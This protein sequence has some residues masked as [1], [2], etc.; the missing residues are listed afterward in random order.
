MLSETEFWYVPV[1]SNGSVTSML[2]IQASNSG[3]K[4]V[5]IGSTIL[6]GGLSRLISARKVHAGESVVVAIW[7]GDGYFLANPN[8]E[9][10]NLY[11]LLSNDQRRSEPDNTLSGNLRAMAHTI[12]QHRK[13]G[14]P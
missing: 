14:A 7:A 5:G 9:P 10:Q 6:A 2:K 1:E 3:C 13:G 4:A 11:S 12:E 8:L